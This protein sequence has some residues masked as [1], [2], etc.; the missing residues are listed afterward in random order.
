M[1]VN[2][3]ILYCVKCYGDENILW[4]INGMFLEN[5]LFIIVDKY[6]FSIKEIFFFGIIK[7][8]YFKKF[9]V[10]R[11]ICII[12]VDEKVFVFMDYIIFEFLVFLYFKYE[13][14]F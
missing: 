4:V 14:D 7:V 5:G 11:G 2:Y 3:V 13:R 12:N 8:I 6:N 10:I 9:S 1:V